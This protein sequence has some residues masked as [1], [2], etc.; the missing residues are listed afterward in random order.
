M[1]IV[2]LFSNS[3]YVTF[4]F[5]CDVVSVWY[6]VNECSI[7]TTITVNQNQG[8]IK[9]PPETNGNIVTVTKHTHLYRSVLP[10]FQVRC[11]SVLGPL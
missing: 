4:P 7:I 8:K 1:G 5:S 2:P 3:Y 10:P 9:T 6:D 11:K